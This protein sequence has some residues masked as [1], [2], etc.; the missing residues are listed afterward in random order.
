[1]T[2]PGSRLDWRDGFTAEMMQPC[3]TL[4]NFVQSIREKAPRIEQIF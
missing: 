3:G 1:M 4:K 2:V